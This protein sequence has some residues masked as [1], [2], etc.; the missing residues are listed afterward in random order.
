MRTSKN[1]SK[2][3]HNR[4]SFKICLCSVAAILLEP[5]PKVAKSG[6]IALENVIHI[7][8]KVTLIVPDDIFADDVADVLLGRSVILFVLF[9]VTAREYLSP[10][11]QIVV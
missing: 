5:F 9:R 11:T 3:I 2:I 8:L 6:R 7:G 10:N 1:N 4:K